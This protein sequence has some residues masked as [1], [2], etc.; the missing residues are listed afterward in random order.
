VTKSRSRVNFIMQF[1]KTNSVSLFAVLFALASPLPALGQSALDSLAGDYV[2]VDIRKNSL[3]ATPARMPPPGADSPIG[4]SVSFT[5]DGVILDGISCKKWGAAKIAAPVDFSSDR[6]LTDLRLPPT[7]SPKSNGDRQI[8]NFFKIDCE[9]EVFT[10]VFQADR[11]V[12]AM[13]WAN[14]ELYLILERPLRSSQIKTLQKALKSMKFY[15]GNV[16]GVFDAETAR[17]TRAWYRYRLSDK[18]A[19]IPLRPA[20]TENLLD[21]LGVLK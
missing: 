19:A 12:L 15:S 17:A 13:D 2:I 8:I 16:T 10:T 3:V 1:F 9:G 5:S 21:A 7:D 14:S 20:I 11:R 6:A 4:K 18:T